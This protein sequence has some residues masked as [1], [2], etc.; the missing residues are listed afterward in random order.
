MT[1]AP[2]YPEAVKEPRTTA[3]AG[4]YFRRALHLRC[5]ACGVSRIFVPW[6]RMRRMRDWFTPLDGCPR[7][8]YPYEREPGYYLMS[9]WAIN[10]GV[11]SVV[12]LAIYGLLEWKFDLPVQQLLLAVL[13]PV[14]LFSLIF[15][16][17][18]KALFLAIDLFF[19]PHEREG[20][21]DGGNVPASPARSA[22]RYPSAKACAALR[23]GRPGAIRLAH[24]AKS[25]LSRCPPFLL[26][27]ALR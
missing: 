14:F 18:S 9:I 10:Y 17:H 15:A 21:S 13:G 1:A 25:P 20:G 22:G 2:A 19:D 7:C 6:R 24:H 4:R 23:S 5:P 27:D 26:R 3:T 12:G 11:G 8:G 16:R